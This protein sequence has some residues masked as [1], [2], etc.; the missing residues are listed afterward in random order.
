MVVM[1]KKMSA[2]GMWLGTNNHSDVFKMGSN[3]LFEVLFE[4]LDCGNDGGM[5][6]LLMVTILALSCLT[7][8]WV[9]MKLE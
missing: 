2:K 5:H 1:E 8:C 3:V 4:F 6:V 9:S 7:S